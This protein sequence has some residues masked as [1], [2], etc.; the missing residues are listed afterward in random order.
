MKTRDHKQ[1]SLAHFN[2]IAGRYDSHRYGKQTRKVHQKVAR[3]VDELRPASLLD[4]GCGNG[5][6][7]ALMQPKVPALAGADLSPEMI[8]FAK[9]RLREAADL[10]VA[11][12]ENLPWEAVRFDC[13]TCNFSFHHYPHPQ[14]VLLEMRRVLKSGGHLVIADPWFP[15]LF[16]HLANL[17]VRLSKLGDVRMYSLDELRSM[18]AA[19]GL[20]TVLAEHHGTASFVVAIKYQ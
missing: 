12:S 7:L 20:K 19:A 2:N 8:K 1:E 15:G 5:S 16:R 14:Q 18:I 17:V 6:F 13:L 10:R 9:K 3:I 4:V 11:D